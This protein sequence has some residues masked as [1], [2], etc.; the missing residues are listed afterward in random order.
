VVGGV[1]FI[2]VSRRY[3]NAKIIESGGATYG[4]KECVSAL[5]FARP[6]FTA[7]QFLEFIAAAAQHNESNIGHGI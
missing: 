4:T 1:A 7:A 2:A 3:S 5:V 6:V